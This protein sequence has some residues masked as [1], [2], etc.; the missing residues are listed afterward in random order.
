M[1]LQKTNFFSLTALFPAMVLLTSFRPPRATASTMPESQI[2]DAEKHASD[3]KKTHVTKFSSPMWMSLVT[4]ISRVTNDDLSET[5]FL[6]IRV[7]HIVKQWR[8]YRI[9]HL[10][11][12]YI[13]DAL[14]FHVSHNV[15]LV[16][17]EKSVSPNCSVLVT[18]PYKSR[19][20]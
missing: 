20:R 6:C 9:P 17:R 12:L 4:C 11:H 15:T 18:L 2:G 14:Y 1:F 10:L 5:R 8:Y 19:L 13:G 7:S 3:A 16:T